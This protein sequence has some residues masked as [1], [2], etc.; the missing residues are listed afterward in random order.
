M[1]IFFYIKWLWMA[2]VITFVSISEYRLLFF[3]PWVLSVSL[4]KWNIYIGVSFKCHLF[5]NLCIIHS[6]VLLAVAQTITGQQT[7]KRR[8]LNLKAGNGFLW[9]LLPFAW[10]L[11]I[12]PYMIIHTIFQK[13]NEGH[14]SVRDFDVAKAYIHIMPD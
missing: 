2:W 3:C 8:L 4:Y 5:H 10:A 1:R 6:L 13:D 7:E 11:L 12:I 14:L 9:G